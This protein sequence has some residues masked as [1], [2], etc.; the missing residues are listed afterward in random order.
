ML[1]AGAAHRVRQQLGAA[2]GQSLGNRV[3]CDTGET[4]ASGEKQ[5]SVCKY[6]EYLSVENCISA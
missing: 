2:A 5:T 3:L 6:E 1:C 4:A